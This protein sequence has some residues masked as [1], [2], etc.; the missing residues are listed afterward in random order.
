M[1]IFLSTRKTERVVWL[2]NG[3]VYKSQ[4]KFLTDNEYY[5]LR[6]MELSGYVPK[7]VEREGIELISMEFIPH[8]KVTDSAEF[9]SHYVH[10]LHALAEAGIRHGDLTEYSVLVRDNRPIL[11]DF[12]ESRE[13]YSEIVSKRPEA[14]S[15]WL[16]KTME[17]LANDK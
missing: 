17:K 6:K 1:K 15:Y 12:A 14:D 5:F 3:R 7:R 11:V 16:K 13:M 10:V 4:P 8:I 9:M 2:E